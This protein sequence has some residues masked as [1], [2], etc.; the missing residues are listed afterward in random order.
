MAISFKFS[1]AKLNEM[2]DLGFTVEHVVSLNDLGVTCKANAEGPKLEFGNASH[3][4]VKDMTIKARPS[5]GPAL[6]TSGPFI[7]QEIDNTVGRAMRQL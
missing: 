5:L 6:T 1:P 7:F 3:G 2:F 4:I